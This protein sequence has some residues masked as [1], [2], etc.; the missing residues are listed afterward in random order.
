MKRQAQKEQT[1]RKLLQ[2]MY[3]VIC[4]NG[5]LNTRVSDVAAAAGVSHGT[6]FVHFESLEALMS[7]ATEE[8]GRRIALRTHALASSSARLD[9]LLRAHLQA[10]REYEPFYTRLVLENRLLPPAVRDIW[11]SIQSAISYHFSQILQH[12]AVAD[13]PEAVLFNA[14]IGLV[15]HYLSNGDLFAP[16]GRVIERWGETLIQSFLQ[17]ATNASA[18]QTL[19]KEKKR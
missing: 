11:I 7:E 8:Y 15:H 18:D 5:M 10:I 12:E 9:D 3:E 17:L 16:N 14:W 4:T 13:V 6:V 1:R 2:A 19:N